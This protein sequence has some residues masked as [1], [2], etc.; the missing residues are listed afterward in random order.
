M[1]IYT[2]FD[3]NDLKSYV[4]GVEDAPLDNFTAQII[5][6]H[7]EKWVAFARYLQLTDAEIEEIK[8]DYPQHYMEQKYQCIM[9]WAKKNGKT[10]T[11]INILRE[12]Y[13]NLNDKS[14]VMKIV[15][16]L[17]NKGM[18]YVQ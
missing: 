15:E 6:R 7:L 12:I 17:K 18:L 16:D 9:R 11:I 8:H 5:A 14:L 2:A 13:F 3:E 1:H 10:G 4:D